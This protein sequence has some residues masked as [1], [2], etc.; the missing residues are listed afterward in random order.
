MESVFMKNS[1]IARVLGKGNIFL[2]LTSGKNIV[3][4]DVLYVL[5]LSRNFVYGNLLN[6]AGLKIVFE[7]AKVIITRNR[8]F[9]RKG[10]LSKWVVCSEYYSYN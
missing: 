3:L 6:K 10:Y 5:S 2:K 4:D 1:T 9:V 7:A 8:E